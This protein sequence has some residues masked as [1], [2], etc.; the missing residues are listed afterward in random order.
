MTVKRYA[1]PTR[2][3][4]ADPTSACDETVKTL[5]GAITPLRGTESFTAAQMGAAT[6]HRV[7][8]DFYDAEG[9]TADMFL[10]FEGRH[11]D[12]E[13]ILR[14]EI[15]KRDVVLTVVERAYSSR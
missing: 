8:L 13:A 4:D 6:T 15:T 2:D 11:F 1:T 5:W 10:E 7:S 12:I 9:I 14:D 3:P